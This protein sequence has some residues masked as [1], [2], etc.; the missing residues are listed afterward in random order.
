M[1]NESKSVVG[2]GQFD[3]RNATLLRGVTIEGITGDR[4]DIEAHY[5]ARVSE[6]F[7]ITASDVFRISDRMIAQEAHPVGPV[8]VDTLHSLEKVSDSD[9]V[10][11][12]RKGYKQFV[13]E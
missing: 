10:S 4:L 13:E 5:D 6:S 3:G 9:T 11:D 7:L 12:I 2:A 8:H 1:P